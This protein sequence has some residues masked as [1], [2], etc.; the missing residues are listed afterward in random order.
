ML[1]ETFTQNLLN[2][3]IVTADQLHIAVL[4]Q[5][6]QNRLLSEILIELHFISEQAMGELLSSYSGYSY[7]DIQKVIIQEHLIECFGLSV[8]MEHSF[9]PFMLDDSVHIVMADPENIIIQDTIK[10]HIDHIFEKKY[11]CKFYHSSAST[12]KNVLLQTMSSSGVA[13]PDAPFEKIFASLFRNAVLEQASDIHFV[14]Y[15]QMVE[16]RIRTHGS[17]EIYTRLELPVYN[18][19]VVRLKLLAKLDIAENRQP[20]SGGCLLTIDNHNIDCRVSFHP[21]LWS[22]SLV[23]RLLATNRKALKLAELGF[24][25]KQTE[26]LQNILKSPFGL[27]LISGATGSGKTTTLHALLQEMDAKSLNIMTLEQPI[28]YRVL[29]VRQTEIKEELGMTFAEG[30]RS[31]LRHDP[32]VLL[33]G[34]IRDEDTAKMALRAAMTG[35]LVLATIHSSNAYTAPARLIDLGISPQLLAGQIIGVLD[36]R[37]VKQHDANKR[38]ASGEL[39]IFNDAMQQIV[40]E[41]GNTLLLKKA[42][43]ESMPV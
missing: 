40:G 21:T 31:M 14:P 19:F 5:Q 32:D 7:I 18:K 38:I 4:E 9:M 28:E 13:E 37:L 24:D 15:E 27:F 11:P 22:E 6:K 26:I 8:C 35:H 29:G 41:G 16:V 2:Q 42:H 10:K 36:Q 30:I 12:I 33:I 34:E 3:G 20:Q 43:L 39:V 23:V 25:Q 1:Q 17:L